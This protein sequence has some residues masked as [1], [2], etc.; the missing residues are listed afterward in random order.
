MAKTGHV[1][2][3]YRMN[4]LEAIQITIPVISSYPDALNQA[5]IEATAGVKEL[6]TYAIAVANAQEAD[7]E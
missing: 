4:E 1:V 7:D 2:A 3:F 5:R 6:L